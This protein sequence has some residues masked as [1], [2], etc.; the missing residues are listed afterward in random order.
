MNPCSAHDTLKLVDH[1]HACIE[2]CG[3]MGNKQMVEY[4]NVADGEERSRM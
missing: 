4:G 1:R 2:M 3:K